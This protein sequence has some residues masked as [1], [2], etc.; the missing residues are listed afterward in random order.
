MIPQ[1][2]NIKIKYDNRGKFI[3]FWPAGNKKFFIKDI[4]L[5]VSKKGVVRG[6]HKQIKNYSNNKIIS[7]LDGRSIHFLVNL[8][9]K[10]INY[11]KIYKFHLNKKIYKSLFIPKEFGHLFQALENNTKILYLSDKKYHKKFDIGYHY[12]S[13]KFK[14]K[15]KK[16][17]LSKRDKKLPLY[18]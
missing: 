12:K 1:L 13:F 7:C 18:N 2:I 11:K 14:F 16:I 17:I 3:K 6:I 4:F 8:D 15:I 10:D 9:K 5:N